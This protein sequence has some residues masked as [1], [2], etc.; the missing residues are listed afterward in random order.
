MKKV[1]RKGN[2]Y[3]EVKVKPETETASVK[4]EENAMKGQP[5]PKHLGGGWYVVDGQKVKGRE[6]AEKILR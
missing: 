2:R 5:Q 6:A 3:V 1:I 4:I